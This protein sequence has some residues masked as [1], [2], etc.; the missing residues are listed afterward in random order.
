VVFLLLY[1]IVISMCYFIGEKTMKVGIIGHAENKFTIESEKSARK[2][3]R[4]ILAQYHNPILVSG[5]CPMGGIDIWAEEVAKDLGLQMDL[6]IPKQNRWD[7]E[8]GYKKRNIDIAKDSDIL[9]II[10]VNGY[11]KEYKGMVFSKCYHCNSNSH[12][13]SGA[14]WTGKVAEKLGKGVIVHIIKNNG[15]NGK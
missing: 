9:H 7:A 4:N 14:C 3:I 13:K 11:P 12:I 2:L 8:Y 15:R 6:K 5:H 10:L 1:A